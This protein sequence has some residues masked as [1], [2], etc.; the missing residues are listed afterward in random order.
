[1]ENR[2][3]NLPDRRPPSIEKERNPMDSVAIVVAIGFI[4]GFL[5]LMFFKS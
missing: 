2:R 5:Y 4:L 1:M 3:V